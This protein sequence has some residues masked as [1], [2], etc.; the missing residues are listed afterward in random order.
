MGWALP[1]NV[2]DDEFLHK[3]VGLEKGLDW[4]KSRLGIHK[5]YSVLSRDYIK[6]TK[7]KDPMAAVAHA[8]ELGDTPVTM[9]VRAAQRALAHTGI[10]PEQIGM[11]VANN[12]TPFDLLPTM[13]NAVAKALGIPGGPHI[14]VNSACSSFARHMKLLGDT[15]SGDWPEYALTVQSSAYTT[16]TDYSPKSI[17]GYIWGDGAA[18]QISSYRHPG[19]MRIEPI[20]FATSPKDA[21]AIGVDICGHFHQD[22]AAVRE[23][24]IR[25]T[26]EM[27]EQIAAVKKLYAEDVYT[28]SHQANY[29]MQN[30]I[31]GHLRLPPERH[32]RNVHQQGNIAAAG[33]PSVLAQNWDK[34]KKGDQI[35]Y[36]V[37]GAGLAWGG[38]YMEVVA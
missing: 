21:D 10:K 38:G 17:D 12:D 1:A 16:R 3:E 31:L 22:G 14:D 5:R 20:V 37:L 18:A 30:S 9:A 2:I 13:A 24:S 26:V 4:N 15:Y 29:V 25:K 27:F 6:S 7:N 36:A 11:V 23:F 35:V 8:R 28:V 34:F 32:L 33:A 19:R